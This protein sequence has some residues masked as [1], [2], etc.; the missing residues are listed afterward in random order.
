MSVFTAVFRR[1]AVLSF[2]F[3]PLAST[4]RAQATATPAA[5]DTPSAKE[6]AEWIIDK[7]P[8]LKWAHY[9]DDVHSRT[10]VA[11]EAALDQNACRLRLT[12]DAENERTFGDRT[13]ETSFVQTWWLDLSR[14]KVS[15]AV[16][17][18][19][20]SLEDYGKTALTLS[21]RDGTRTI[22]ATTRIGN[23]QSDN[24]S[25]SMELDADDK[26]LVERIRKAFSHLSTICYKREPF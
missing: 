12:R 9:R 5:G 26:V 25:L 24:A 11:Y 14:L 19:G 21:T 2:A 1:L 6:T 10:R 8:A 17:E 7:L 15:D 20:V 3:A 18:G 13:S 16:K 22:R 23:Q 4:L